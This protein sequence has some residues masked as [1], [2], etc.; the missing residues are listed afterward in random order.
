MAKTKSA[1]KR[2]KTSEKRRLNNKI[3]KS[4]IKTFLKKSFNA[5][6]NYKTNPI[7]ETLETIERQISLTY[8]KIDKAIKRGVIHRNKGSRKKAQLANHLQKIKSLSL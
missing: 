8:S 3:Y 2:I 5:I 6:A 4:T 1:L 7:L